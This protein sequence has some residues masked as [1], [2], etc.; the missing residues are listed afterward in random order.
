MTERLQWK[1]EKDGVSIIEVI[2]KGIGTECSVCGQK[3][4]VKG[5]NF[6]CPACGFEEN[7]KINGAK[8]ALNRGKT[9]KQLN[10]QFPKK[11]EENNNNITNK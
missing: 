10:K 7:K 5:E 4:N 11:N 6:R 2:G 1:C 3:G 9:G 8:N